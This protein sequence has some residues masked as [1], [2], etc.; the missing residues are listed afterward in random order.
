MIQSI[1][2]ENHAIKLQGLGCT[3]RGFCPLACFLAPLSVTCVSCILSCVFSCALISLPACSSN[4][5]W[6]EHSMAT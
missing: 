2:D 6:F 3:L 1:P 4:W 5:D